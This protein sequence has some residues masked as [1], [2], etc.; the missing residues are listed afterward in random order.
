M[1]M[2]NGSAALLVEEGDTLWKLG[3]SLG[4]DWRRLQ[5]F[6]GLDSDLILAGATL[7]VP[8]RPWLP[9]RVWSHGARLEPLL[10]EAGDTAWEIA[11]GLGLLVEELQEL[12]LHLA[13]LDLLFPGD[14][15]FVPHCPSQWIQRRQVFREVR[16]R[17]KAFGSANATFFDVF[18]PPRDVDEYRQR[19][20]LLL[21]A[22]RDV[23]SSSM[24]PAPIGDGGRSIGPL[25]ISTDY[26]E[27]AWWQKDPSGAK[28][29]LCDE[30]EYAERTAVNYWLR[31]CPWSL[32]F[33]DLETLARTH[34]GGPQ[35]WFHMATIRYWR[36][37]ARSLK[38]RGFKKRIPELLEERQAPLL[39]SM[40]FPFPPDTSSCVTG[41]GRSSS[42]YTP[43]VA[44]IKN[45]ISAAS[46]GRMKTS[47]P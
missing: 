25:Q 5:S 2:A 24:V 1:A 46:P 45:V 39:L 30:V 10:V 4:I 29:E 13:T 7:R 38:S 11:Q 26:H 36:K 21:D 37:V 42:D 43:A 12:N 16:A 20:R 15:L 33:D 18:P 8:P 40:H 9:R 34:N 23:E 19:H 17:T 27:D 14:I 31:Y 35:W 28:Y 3:E 22:M 6:N 44:V 41:G 47:S 32:E